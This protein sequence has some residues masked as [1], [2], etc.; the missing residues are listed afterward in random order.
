LS[1]FDG[2]FLKHLAGSVAKSS[3]WFEPGTICL[4]HQLPG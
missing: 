2:I 3:I 4:H 1:Q